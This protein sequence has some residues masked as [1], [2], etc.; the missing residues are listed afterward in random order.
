MVN[1]AV[2]W[3]FDTSVSSCRKPAALFKWKHVTYIN[4]WG[5]RPAN[6]L[7][8]EIYVPDVITYDVGLRHNRVS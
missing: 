5:V 7:N 8:S 4:M 1:N 6:K 3:Q 2:M